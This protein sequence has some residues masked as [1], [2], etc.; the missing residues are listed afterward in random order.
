MDEA[1]RFKN[2]L[3]YKIMVHESNKKRKEDEDSLTSVGAK[4][5][6]LVVTSDK[7][8]TLCDLFEEEHVVEEESDVE[9]DSEEEDDNE[10]EDEACT[11]NEETE[12]QPW[13]SSHQMFSFNR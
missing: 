2:T 13:P 12:T 4:L 10:D 9:E 6:R 3:C 5:K 7:H 1:E 11:G 8:S